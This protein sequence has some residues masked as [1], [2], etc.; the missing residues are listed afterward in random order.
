[1]SSEQQLTGKVIKS[2][3]SSLTNFSCEFADGTGLVLKAVDAPQPWLSGEVV[4]AD[5]LPREADAVCKVDWSWI[6]GSAI[7]IAQISE[8]DA[9][10]QLDKAGLLRISIQLWQ[11]KP[12]LAFQPYRPA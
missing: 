7:R 2:A 1:M 6:V 9:Q 4:Q 12:F 10:L 8:K 3:T 5:A 11:G